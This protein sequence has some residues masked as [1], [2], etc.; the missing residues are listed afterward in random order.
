MPPRALLPQALY[1]GSEH[2]HTEEQ[3]IEPD[4]DGDHVEG[5][6]EDGHG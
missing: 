6:E 5:R 4:P 1:S 2:Q 3:G